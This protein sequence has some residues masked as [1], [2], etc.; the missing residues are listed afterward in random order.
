MKRASILFVVF[1]L[2]MVAVTPSFAQSFNLVAPGGNTLIRDVDGDL[3]HFVWGTVAGATSYE[4][5]LFKVSTN[6]RAPIGT[7]FSLDLPLGYCNADYCYYA[8]SGPQYATMD[9]G[10]Y[11]WTVIASTASGDIEASNAPNY[12]SINTAPIG[13]I[14]NPGFES[15]ALSPWKGAG[16]TNDKLKP[17]KGNAGSWGFLF[18]GSA[19]ENAVLSQAVI[20]THLGIDNN[21]SLSFT[22]EYKAA[23]GALNLRFILTLVYANGT[24]LAKDKVILTAVPNAAFTQVAGVVAPDGPLKKVKA[25]LS[26]RSTS[27]KAFVDNIQVVLA[28]QP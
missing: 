19:A 18:N 28:G 20:V 15:G 25:T 26:H 1:G 13:L 17:G 6:P 21:D 3:P 7:V 5:S 11:A 10:E 8:P 27:G 9:T 14:A 4:L 2:L 12:F 16:L 22:G 23:S 24:G